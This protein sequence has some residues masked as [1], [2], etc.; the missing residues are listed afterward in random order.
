MNVISQAT[1]IVRRKW[2]RVGTGWKVTLLVFLILAVVVGILFTTIW[3]LGKLV[4]S[5]GSGKKNMDI[6]FPRRVR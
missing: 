2:G 5:L 1:D 4:K 3:L 6:Y